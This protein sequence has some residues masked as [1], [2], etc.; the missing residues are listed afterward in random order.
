MKSFCYLAVFSFAVASCA[1]I[2]S[3]QAFA[4]AAYQ[5]QAYSD[6]TLTMKAQHIPGKVECENYD[7]GGEGVSYHDVDVKNSG[8]GG[9]NKA[10]DYLSRFRENESVDIS[11]TKYD[12]NTDNSAF[13]LVE[14]E[15]NQ[16]YVGWTEPGEWLKYT[17]E[18]EQAGEYNIG[19]MYTSNRGGSIRLAFDNNKT[20]DLAIPTTFDAD[21][22]VSWRQWHHWNF[23]PQLA[24]VNLAKGANVMTVYIEKEGDFNLDYFDFSLVK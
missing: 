17:I 5:G 11:Y 16:L 15:E 1:I 14:V 4:K 13:N 2:N 7:F 24:N 12:R 8:S 20:K 22:P 21:D 18:V 23:L 10:N 9:L 3:P 6:G 19:L